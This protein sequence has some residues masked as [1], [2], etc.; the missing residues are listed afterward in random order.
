MDLTYNQKPPPAL[1]PKQTNE[2]NAA[3]K[4]LFQLG[5]GTKPSHTGSQTCK[6][7]GTGTKPMNNNK[8]KWMMES[9]QRQIVSFFYDDY[10]C[11][12]NKFI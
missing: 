3:D 1:H 8:N 12:D 5:L 7:E 6:T 4:N 9:V 11:D 10:H 2:A